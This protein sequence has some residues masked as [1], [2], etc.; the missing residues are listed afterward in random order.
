MA[1]PPLIIE[2]AVNGGTPKSR[3]RNVPRTPM[4]IAEDGIACVEAG[5]S[6]VHN[7][8]NEGVVGATSE[9]HASEPYIE[10]WRAI[11]AKKPDTLLYPT[12]A[13]GGPQTKIELRY[14]HI[15]ALAEAGVTRLGLIDCGSVNVGSLGPDG[16]PMLADSPYVNTL[17]D[18]RYMFDTCMRMRLSPSVS[19]FEPG[20]LRVALGYHRA[21]RLFP[22]ALIKLYFGG[23]NSLFGLPPTAT[24]L[25]AYLAMLEGSGL[26][27][28]VAT[29]GGDVIG[30][31]L[32]KI[33]IERGG[34]VRVGLEDYAGP[35]E[36]VR[37]TELVQELV[38]LANECGRPIATPKEAAGILGIPNP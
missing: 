7:H 35:R 37:N 34:H 22:G 20:F 12:M 31:G 24:S 23:P 33:A 26:Q 10:A 2:A 15:P 13:S 11:L 1:I 16:L 32:A 18:S 28:S 9:V 38:A 25:D 17:S 27:W 19:I 8:N 29:L 5:A 4:E 36:H 3:N 14:S 21:G 6:I 30:N